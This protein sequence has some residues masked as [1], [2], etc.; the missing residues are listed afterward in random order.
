MSSYRDAYGRSLEYLRVSVTDRCNFRCPY[1]RPE[2]G[3]IYDPPADH[4]NAAEI[5]RVVGI[6]Q[7]LGVRAVRFTGGEP[8][9]RRDL[10]EVIAAV[11]DRG[12]TDLALTTNAWRLA[13]R[14]EALW[15]AGLRRI[16]VSL[17]ALDP[18]T[19]RRLSGGLEI[20]PTLSGIEAAVQQGFEVKT[21]TV[22][23]GGEND[24]ALLDLATFAW[25][26]GLTPRFI[27]LMPIGAGALATR[28]RIDAEQII[29][30]FD[31]VA[32]SQSEA[33][34][35]GR[36]PASYWYHEGKK[37]QKFGVIGATTRNFCASCNR[38][39]LT[40]T[41]GLRPCLASNL[42]YELRPLLRRDA[43]DEE[44]LEAIL[45]GMGLKP[46]GHRFHDGRAGENAMRGIG[47]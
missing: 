35:Y 10:P 34:T 19:F 8:L 22:V 46:E 26:R 30:T 31:A 47:G 29:Q 44:L 6:S 41:G 27:E 5:A 45:E 38:A 17:D 36:G 7:Q 15:Q 4:L 21:N 25:D 28:Q 42:G 37:D 3:E 39:R 16:N 11:R 18:S 24:R 1:C 33:R 2:T 40:A 9:L 20:E 23:M 32:E 14:T 43:S 13:D 12:L